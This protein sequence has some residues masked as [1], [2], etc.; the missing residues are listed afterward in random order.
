MCGWQSGL[1]R[2]LEETAAQHDTEIKEIMDSTTLKFAEIEAFRETSET[3]L[4]CEIETAEQKLRDKIQQS[5]EQ[6]KRDKLAEAAEREATEDEKRAASADLLSGMESCVKNLE[7]WAQNT[8]A[9]L[10]THDTDLALNRDELET[11]QD[12]F[13]QSKQDSD[14]AVRTVRTVREAQVAGMRELKAG[15]ERLQALHY[16]SIYITI[17]LPFTLHLPS[18]YPAGFSGWR[19]PRL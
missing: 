7:I 8:A 14:E 12:D 11:L 15:W 18:I 3:A 6:A 2:Q 16:T 10:T 5:A 4:R 17:Y 13:A 19:A 1:Q 9:K